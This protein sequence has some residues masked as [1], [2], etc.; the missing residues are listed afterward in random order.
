MYMLSKMSWVDTLSVIVFVCVFESAKDIL[1]M[2]KID[3]GPLMMN[4]RF[5]IDWRGR[6]H[7]KD[8]HHIIRKGPTFITFR[9]LSVVGTGQVRILPIC[10]QANL[11][12]MWNSRYSL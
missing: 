7:Q 9:L 8:S 3:T 12:H 6:S 10:R 4:D 2:I 1:L 11:F 5:Q